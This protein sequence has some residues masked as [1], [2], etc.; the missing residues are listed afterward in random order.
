MAAGGL[1]MTLSEIMAQTHRWHGLMLGLL[2]VAMMHL[3]GATNASRDN[4]GLAEPWPALLSSEPA[5]AD[6]SV[7]L[8]QRRAIDTL[9][10][11]TQAG[12]EP[13]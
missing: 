4:D 11:L 6:P 9:E 10:K 13:L 8:L 7:V 12:A 3:S 5:S 1:A 2:V